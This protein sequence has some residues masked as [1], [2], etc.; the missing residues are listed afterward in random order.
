MLS[1]FLPVFFL[2]LIFSW[3]AFYV[4]SKKVSSVDNLL[5]NIASQSK[6]A[7]KENLNGYDDKGYSTYFLSDQ[8]KQQVNSVITPQDWETLSFKQIDEK[9]VWAWYKPIGDSGDPWYTISPEEV[10]TVIPQDEW[11]TLSFKD[12]DAKL[13]QAGFPPVWDP[14]DPLYAL[15]PA[16]IKELYGD[17]GSITYIG[18]KQIHLIEDALNIQSLFFLFGAFIFPLFSLLFLAY[19]FSLRAQKP[20][21]EAVEKQKQFVSDVSHEI[22]TPLA[23]M[24]SEAEV[25]LRDTKATKQEYELF[26]QHT[27]EDVNRLNNLATHLLSLTKLEHTKVIQKEPFLLRELLDDLNE[28]FTPLAHKKGISLHTK[29]DTSILLHSDKEKVYQIL[30]ILLDNAIKYSDKKWKK[31]SIEVKK[32][33]HYLDILI[34]DE[35]EGIEE[36]HI[37]KVFERFYRVTED[38][39]EEGFGLGLPIAQALSEKINWKL[40]LISQV[41]VWTTAT[42]RIK[43]E[44]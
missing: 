43:Y 7:G 39:R 21:E 14:K 1:Y 15:S 2:F 30:S 8:E 28:R 6:A 17:T 24:K 31:V 33:S 41:W 44:R 10:N 20:L 34:K 32:H 36:K 35:G 19:Y 18:E 9:L 40:S 37:K 16:K 5:K 12:L 4:I 23:L 13:Q 11:D 25:L 22:R 27:I 42:L 3:G 29:V 38:R 26:A